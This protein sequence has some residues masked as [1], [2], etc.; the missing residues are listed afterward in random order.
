MWQ[1]GVD[2][3]EDLPSDVCEK[4]QQWCAEI[5]ALPQLS[6]PRRYD[7]DL[8]EGETIDEHKEIHVFCDASQTAYCAAEYLKIVKSDGN[9]KCSLIMAK[10]R[11]RNY[12][13]THL[14]LDKSQ[15]K[16][17]TDSMIIFHWIKSNAKQ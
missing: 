9:C 2:W 10:T 4:W 3:D 8:S 6:V 14:I 12:V 11:L 17:W 16:L 15:L 7:A 1:R 5:P 13:L